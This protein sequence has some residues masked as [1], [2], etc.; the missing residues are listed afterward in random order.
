MKGTYGGFGS[1]VDTFL[2]LVPADDDK[3]TFDVLDSIRGV[4]VSG[5][6]MIQHTV[7]RRF[8]ETNFSPEPWEL[9]E[10]L[11]N[12]NRREAPL[13]ALHQPPIQISVHPPSYL[14]HTITPLSGEFLPQI[15]SLVI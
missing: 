7:Y 10:P 3:S 1:H 9:A 8:K 2:E 11:L 15:H 13:E 4:R 5:S 6:A 12:L 14:L